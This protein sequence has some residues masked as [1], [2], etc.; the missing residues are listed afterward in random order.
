MP[1]ETKI[2]IF[3]EGQCKRETGGIG[4]V[5][6]WI[7]LEFSYIFL[8][9]REISDLA[10]FFSLFFFFFFGV[11]YLPRKPCSLESPLF[12]VIE[13]DFKPD[14]FLFEVSKLGFFVTLMFLLVEVGG[15]WS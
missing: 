10:F 3:L 8:H 13:M 7:R 11:V 14:V 4:S 1:R 9:L 12:N 6:L 2:E 15:L 5:F